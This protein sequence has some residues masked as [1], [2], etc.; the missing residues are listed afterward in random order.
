MEKYEQFLTKNLKEKIET[1]P[2]INEINRFE[3]K[4]QH[5]PKQFVS[6]W[7][8]EKSPEEKQRVRY[9]SLTQQAHINRPRR[10]KS[11]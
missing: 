9:Y 11:K 4:A 5:P 8:W 7:Y 2:E 10:E 6:K 1:K 3:A